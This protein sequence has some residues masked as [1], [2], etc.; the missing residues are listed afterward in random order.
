MFVCVHACECIMCVRVLCVQERECVCVH[1]CK[2]VC[3]ARMHACVCVRPCVC[4]CVHTH[5]C[6]CRLSSISYRHKWNYIPK[7]CQPIG[8]LPI[9]FGTN[10]SSRLC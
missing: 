10:T 8:F 5:T 9:I 3:C 4:V 2:C 6:V 1:V 7:N